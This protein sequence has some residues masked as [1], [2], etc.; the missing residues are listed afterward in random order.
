MRWG[1]KRRF[2]STA[3]IAQVGANGSPT[4]S[5]KLTGGQ[6]LGSLVWTGTHGSERHCFLY[7]SE[8]IV[9]GVVPHSILPGSFRRSTSGEILLGSFFCWQAVVICEDITKFT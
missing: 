9:A 1:Q 7:G 5:K 6:P 3:A 2:I 4:G 8:V